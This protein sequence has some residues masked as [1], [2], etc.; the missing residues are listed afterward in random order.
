MPYAAPVDEM[1]FVIDAL[2]GLDEGAAEVADAVAFA[3]T[4]P[5]EPV[6][7]LLKDVHTPVAKTGVP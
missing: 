4:G 3:E 2:G 6:E 1:R 5:W 7:D